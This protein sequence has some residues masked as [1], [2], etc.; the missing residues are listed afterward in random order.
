MRTARESKGW[1]IDD[2]M[3]KET[4]K[5]VVEAATS[6]TTDPL[7]KW[8]KKKKGGIPHE[9]QLEAMVPPLVQPFCSLFYFHFS[10]RLS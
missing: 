8:N 7:E 6:S 10:K 9:V 2:D 1:N 4:A 5:A 3:I